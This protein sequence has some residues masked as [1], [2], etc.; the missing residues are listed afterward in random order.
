MVGEMEGEIC[1]DISPIYSVD[2]GCRDIVPWK[3][4]GLGG[5]PPD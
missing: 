4:A 2:V 1:N 3:L 5:F